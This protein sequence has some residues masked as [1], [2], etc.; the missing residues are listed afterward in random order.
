MLRKFHQ[1]NRS[2]AE[3]EDVAVG[4][5][6]R[7]LSRK[8]EFR[9]KAAAGERGGRV[10][11]TPMAAEKP[12]KKASPFANG[13]AGQGQTALMRTSKKGAQ[14]NGREGQGGAENPNS[15]QELVERGLIVL[16]KGKLK[17]A[18]DRQCELVKANL[19]TLSGTGG[20]KFR[21]KERNDNKSN[22]ANQCFGGDGT[23]G[24][25]IRLITAQL[26]NRP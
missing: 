26:P 4:Q 8:R 16:Q 23:A 11:T 21:L 25:R 5:Y 10:K 3:L 1:P 22:P 18:R 9:P 20:K 2:E 13:T 24:E 19:K 15:R 12:A 7:L 14:R 6:G 17:G